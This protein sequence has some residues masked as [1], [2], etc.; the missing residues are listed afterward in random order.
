MLLICVIDFWHKNFFNICCI[1]V[2][3][4]NMSLIELTNW[5]FVL[6]CGSVIFFLIYL[7][8]HN[9]SRKIRQPLILLCEVH[10]AMLYIL[11]INLI[12]HAL[13]RKGSLTMEVLLQLGGHCL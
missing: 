9:I 7:L 2:S 5:C 11:E 4:I 13:E 1:Q 6:T 8:S 12:S 10:F 3:D